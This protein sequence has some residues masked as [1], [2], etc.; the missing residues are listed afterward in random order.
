MLKAP[1][2]FYN[3]LERQILLLQILYTH[4]AQRN[5]NSG[6][7]KELKEILKTLKTELPV[8]RK[9]YV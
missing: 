4:T 7:V 2:P 9:L 6:Q 8:K 5:I 1:A 3:P